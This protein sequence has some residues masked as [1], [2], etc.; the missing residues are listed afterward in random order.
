[1]ARKREYKIEST[2]LRAVNSLLRAMTHSYVMA[3]KREC[4]NFG[5]KIKINFGHKIE[6]CEFI[7][8]LDI[9]LQC[10]AT[11]CSV[12]QCVLQMCFSV[13]QCVAVWYS[14]CCRCAADVLQFVDL[15]LSHGTHINEAY[16]MSHR[17]EYVTNMN[18]SCHTYE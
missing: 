17:Y 7:P 18:A 4:T 2:K 6:S 13:L 11:C 10:V 8:E 1:M 9:E 15:K 16:T 3:R 5:H 12:V 14:V